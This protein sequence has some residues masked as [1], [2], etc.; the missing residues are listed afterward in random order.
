MGR[1]TARGEPRKSINVRY[2]FLEIAGSADDSIVIPVKADTRPEE[3]PLGFRVCRSIVHE[4]DFLGPPGVT[5][6]GLE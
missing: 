5:K 4:A 6:E 1:D 3:T 2:R